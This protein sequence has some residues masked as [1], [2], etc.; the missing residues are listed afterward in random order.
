M[1]LPKIPIGVGFP[2]Y[3]GVEYINKA[4]EAANT[5]REDSAT[6]KITSQNAE[7]TASAA[8]IKAESVQEQFNQVVIEGDSSVEAAQARV[9]AEGN[10]FTTLKERLDT[11]DMQLINTSKEI[12]DIEGSIVYAEKFPIQIPETDDTARL[13]RMIDAAGV[14]GRI[15]FNKPNTVYTISSTINVVNPE[16]VLFSDFRSEYAPKIKCTTPNITMF[17]VK[18]Y[19]FGIKGIQL[20]GDGTPTE[21]FTPTVNGIEIDR[22]DGSGEETLSNLDV[23]IHD[24]GFLYLKDCIITNGRNVHVTNNMFSNSLRGITGEQYLNTECRGYRIYNNRFHSMGFN[25]A[26]LST[27]ETSHCVKISEKAYG[28]EIRDNFADFC[29]EFY[30]GPVSRS[31][32][33]NNHIYNSYGDGITLTPPTNS[34]LEFGWEVKGNCILSSTTGDMTA[35]TMQ[36]GI[37]GKLGNLDNGQI[38]DN[39]IALSRRDGIYLETASNVEIKNNYVLNPNK[40]AN[41]DGILY[42]GISVQAGNGNTIKGNRVRSTVPNGTKPRNGIFNN[43]NYSIIEQNFINNFTTE[44]SN[45]QL[46]TVVKTKSGS[47]PTSG[48]WGVGSEIEIATPVAGGYRHQVCVIAGTPGTWKGYGVIQN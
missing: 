48:T 15:K 12:G 13:Q 11:G 32:I 37:Y 40:Y 18:H 31:K 39:H 22:S 16:V 28:N 17:K 25:A 45:Q 24:C 23:E 19:S 44:I 1:T 2:L 47:A 27:G 14:V 5:A 41:I 6:A 43:S 29:K 8:E 9:D 10:S 46:N 30:I 42:D 20:E 26:P 36:Y 3:K 7:N 33:S 4:I 21:P 38:S 34:S 35:I